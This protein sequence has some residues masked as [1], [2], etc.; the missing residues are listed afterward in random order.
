MGS[1]FRVDH[2]LSVLPGLVAI[3]GAAVARALGAT[4]LAVRLANVGY[5]FTVIGLALAIGRGTPAISSDHELSTAPPRNSLLLRRPLLW[6]FMMSLPL[7]ALILRHVLFQEGLPLYEDMTFPRRLDLY[8]AHLR[9][10]WD[11][12][13]SVRLA[14]F[15]NWPLQM[16]ASLLSASAEWYAKGLLAFA[17]ASGG[18]GAFALGVHFSRGHASR[19]RIATGA[20]CGLAYLFNPW[21][22]RSLLGYTN[23]LIG[24]GLAPVAGLC[25]ARSVVSK[26]RIRAA[27]ACLCGILLGFAAIDIRNV[28]FLG[29]MSAAAAGICL[30]SR[31]TWSGA[32]SV[33]RA[34]A[35]PIFWIALFL[36][37]SILSFGWGSG[38][39]RLGS[40]FQGLLT[41]RADLWNTLRADGFFV[42]SPI[43]RFAEQGWTA[44]ISF[45]PVLL[46]SSTLLVR[47]PSRP[48]LAGAGVFLIFAGLAAG[49]RGPTGALFRGLFD[50]T[51]GSR[52]A[53]LVREPPKFAFIVAGSLALLL[54][55][56]AGTIAEQKRTILRGPLV[57]LLV[58]AV[59]VP[60]SPMAL[61]DLRLYGSA[62][63]TN[64][65]LA[66]HRVPQA[67]EKLGR[68]LDRSCRP[69]K[70]LFVPF[71]YGQSGYRWNGL[72]NVT[73]FY[74]LNVPVPS[75]VPTGGENS[76]LLWHWYYDLL[77]QDRTREVGRHIAS[78]GFRCVVFHDDYLS[79][80]SFRGDTPEAVRTALLRQSDLKPIFREHRPGIA[81][82]VYEVT[83]WRSSPW[84]AEPAFLFG[85]FDLADELLSIP[86]LDLSQSIAPLF[87]DDY[88][89]IALAPKGVRMRA[90]EGDL[91]EVVASR[92]P[93]D[94][95][96]EQP[97]GTTALDPREGWTDWAVLG[98][99]DFPAYASS[100]AWPLSFQNVFGS[101]WNLGER[102]T[103]TVRPA[104]RLII[105]VQSSGIRNA[106]LLVRVAHHDG[107]GVL[108]V[109]LDKRVQ[110]D[111]DTRSNSKAH[112]SSVA[113]QLGNV[114]P[115]RHILTIT[116]SAGAN[117]V[118]AVAIISK[119][120]LFT[121][122]QNLQHDL[123]A[124]GETAWLL[125]STQP[126]RGEQKFEIALPEGT[127]SVLARDSAS[128]SRIAVRTRNHVVSGRTKQGAWSLL[129]NVSLPKGRSPVTV[130][131]PTDVSV[132]IMSQGWLSLRTQGV[133]AVISEGGR[134]PHESHVRSTARRPMLLVSPE[135]DEP[136]WECGIDGTRG[137]PL[138]VW[139][140]ILG[141]EVPTG[142][143]TIRTAYVP[144][145]R[146]H[147]ARQMGIV[148]AS[149][150]L[151]STLLSWLVLA[152][153]GLAQRRRWRT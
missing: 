125:R 136:G 124:S 44:L 5:V 51:P 60:M 106:V 102:Y 66:A 138:R 28:F 128:G 97:A 108:S 146:H 78:L 152:R 131:Y 75:I 83:P 14:Q 3:A 42:E 32:S 12:G 61:G 100:S 137:R 134:S 15:F 150:A 10:A 86:D 127:Y 34:A 80:W 4:D 135:R 20:I 19:G 109:R 36:A 39:P 37:P 143:H 133:T 11:A 40:S 98:N 6:G 142:S 111:I 115:G 77:L 122:Q 54:G 23:L 22:Y 116:N 121:V 69:G 147:L 63:A 112:L 33:V 114:A 7:V 107:G 103:A 55:W 95:L 82:E 48:V 145:D 101:S 79:A 129:G 9:F 120:D 1:V 110:F 43:T 91:Q 89:R 117:L 47:R 144:E 56:F 76:R 8:D 45:A 153:H 65:R 126:A 41:R 17:L 24:Y 59:V 130:R 81:L 25:F 16:P 70:T 52:L 68:F 49:P 26:G 29:L 149:L 104:A 18:A 96:V 90:I 67:Y 105:P 92:I 2:R 119:E 35:F 123:S 73:D 31:R 94:N 50:H 30:L 84:I 132:M 53:F 148:V 71:E 85:G 62:G 93:R 118:G 38:I 151:L 57:L 88:S 64:S 46:A 72:N 74:W 58:L 139:S 27:Y 87:M 141:C 99:G 13:R 21:V 140:L 113:V